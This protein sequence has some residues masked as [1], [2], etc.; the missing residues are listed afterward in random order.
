MCHF[1]VKQHRASMESV[2]ATHPLELVHIDYLCLELG[3]GKEENVLVVMDHLTCYAQ[4]YVTKSPMVQTTT[5]TLWD[6]FIVHYGLQE[7]F[8]SDQGRNFESEIIADL[9][10]LTGTKKLRTSSYHPQTNGQCESF[11][12]T[13]INMLGILPPEYH[14][15]WK[16]S[17]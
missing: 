12:S 5:K 3:K 11:N 17:I 9:C 16:A 2:M 4:A 14:S 13:L 8:L 1:K 6:N 15:G 7:K 10:K